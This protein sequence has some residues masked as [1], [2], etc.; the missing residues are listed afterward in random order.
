MEKR[1]NKLTRHNKRHPRVLV[2]LLARKEKNEVG[3]PKNAA[4]K[5]IIDNESCKKY[6]EMREL[7]LNR[8]K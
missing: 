4:Y 2:L 8:E 5:Q 1:K 6:F 3:R 7:A